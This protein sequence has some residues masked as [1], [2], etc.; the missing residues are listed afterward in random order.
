[1]IYKILSFFFLIM[2]ITGAYGL[3]P[4]VSVP[5]V[6]DRSTGDGEEGILL[7]AEVIVTNGTG[8]V[9]VDTN[10]YTQ[11]DLQGSARLAAMVASDIL[12]IDEKAYDFYY[13]IDI[14]SPIIGGPSAGGALTVATIAAINKWPLKPNVVMTGTINPDGSIGPVGG[15]PFKLKAAA[16]KNAVLFMI[17]E[18]QSNVTVINTSTRSRGALIISDE[19][20]ETVDVIKLGKELN[21]TVKEVNTIQEVVREFTGHEITKTAYKGTILT[22][23]YMDLLKPLAHNLKAESGN[24]YKE[25]ISTTGENQF[26]KMAKDILDRA[27]KMY[28][29]QKYY[30]ATSLYF[31]SMFTM[32]SVVWKDGY[33]KASDKEQYLMELAK[34][35]DRQIN[36]SEEDLE[37]FTLYGVS[38]VEA[39]GAAESRITTARIR[40][41]EAKKMNDT[42]EKIS[43]FAFANERARTAQ[44]WLTL[45]TPDGKIIPE[46][47]LKDRA[48]WYLSQAQSIN[49]YMVT[50]I[51]ESGSHPDIMGGAAEDIDH[52]QKEM[53]R[54]YYS[55]AIFDSLQATIKASTSIGLLGKDDADK[56]VKESYEDARVAIN[57]ARTA[58]IEPTLAVSAYEYGETMTNQ[59]EKI[60]QYSYAK[61]IAKTS[62][63]LKSH[64]IVSNQTPIKPVITPYASQPFEPVPSPNGT[65]KKS[66]TTIE[67]PGFEAIAAISMLLLF[68]ILKKR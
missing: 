21:V 26:T 36:R 43:S 20:E 48:G 2:T 16:A 57:E 6:A 61:M 8:H 68:R 62:I 54:G 37:N 52:A 19:K 15:I 45:A 65:S 5:L 13:I 60:S 10:P 1:M 30:A 51:S 55:G 63:V 3:E 31:N 59:Y 4:G 7:G 39:V 11:V 40:L 14:S 18:G 28:D 64:A 35:V 27:D 17:P 29:D 9:F 44:W 22:T 58:G 33:D 67:V 47:I 25:M 23:Q 32:R 66:K 38:D 34:R 56:K 42:G 49:T 46:E 41:D 53:G 24:M 12:G 50:L